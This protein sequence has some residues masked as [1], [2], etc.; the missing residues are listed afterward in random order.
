MKTKYKIEPSMYGD[1]E[2]VKSIEINLE[3]IEGLLFHKALLQFAFNDENNQTDRQDAI[4]M[5]DEFEI[6]TGKAVGMTPE[7]IDAFKRSFRK[8]TD[9]AWK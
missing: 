3:P 9:C 5:C 6:A 1:Y 2:A 7:E 8:Q 4:R